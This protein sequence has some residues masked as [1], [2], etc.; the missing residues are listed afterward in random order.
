MSVFKVDDKGLEVIKHSVAAVE[1]T[2]SLLTKLATRYASEGYGRA[3]PPTMPFAVAHTLFSGPPGTGKTTRAEEAASLMGCTEENGLFIRTTPDAIRTPNDLV[4]LLMTRL[5]WQG[6][7][8][9][10]GKIDHTACSKCRIIDP[11]N[12]RGPITPQ[13][14]F[15]DEIH[16]LDKDV[17]VAMLMILNDF[18]YQYK[19]K[20]MV[21]DVYFPKFTCF[22][23]TTDPGK[24]PKPLRTRFKNKVYVNYYTD[25]EMLD[26]VKSIVRKRGWEIDPDAAGILARISQGIPREAVNHVEG[27]YSCLCYLV[28]SGKLPITAREQCRFTTTLAKFYADSRGFLEDGLSYDQIRLLNFLNREV[29]GKFVTAG[30]KKILDALG[31]D[32]QRYA[33][34]VEPRLVARGLI[35]TTRA[36]RITTKGSR[37]LEEL[38]ER[39]YAGEVSETL[40]IETL[41]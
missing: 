29:D 41:R 24:L 9:N 14:L 3:L 10:R 22:G 18:R 27:I 6:Y 12:P 11:V 32:L 19:D 38:E 23:A 35:D 36:R 15:I 5:S 2:N 13:V 25:E 30:I 21:R 40:Q 31:W 20:D 33:D 1:H 26:I 37:Y 16:D 39:Q 4:K 34:E 17:Q 28:K 8:C 7:L